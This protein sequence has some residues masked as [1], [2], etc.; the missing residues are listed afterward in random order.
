M[1]CLLTV[2]QWRR[3]QIIGFLTAVVQ[4]VRDKIKQPVKLMGIMPPVI[5]AHRHR[6]VGITGIQFNQQTRLFHRRGH[7]VRDHHRTGNIRAFR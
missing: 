1:C 4:A 7:H 2:R 6:F 5:A 3:R